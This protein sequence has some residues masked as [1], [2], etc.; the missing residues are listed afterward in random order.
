MM[1][2]LVGF[3]RYCNCENILKV[4][5]VTLVLFTMTGCVEQA[6]RVIV[7]PARAGGG[8]WVG[9][10]FLALFVGAMFDNRKPLT[11]EQV[12]LHNAAVRE[13]EDEKR[14][15]E[16]MDLPAGLTPSSSNFAY[17]NEIISTAIVVKSQTL[18]LDHVFHVYSKDSS[19][20][21]SEWQSSEIS[22]VVIQNPDN[23]ERRLFFNLK[24]GVAGWKIIVTWDENKSLITT[25]HPEQSQE[26]SA[27]H[28]SVEN[29]PPVNYTPPQSSYQQRQNM[30]ITKDVDPSGL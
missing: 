4:F 14:R 15:V 25:K 16:A 28:P 5:V 24:N 19:F 3:K 9:L 29:S 21:N 8:G 10:L 7:I 18:S 27:E 11:P 1:N 2:I 30:N 22:N 6:V 23:P 12:Q 26:R 17:A 13:R 20:Q